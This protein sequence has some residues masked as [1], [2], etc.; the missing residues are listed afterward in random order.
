M[1]CLQMFDD[2]ESGE[3]DFQEFCR[4]LFPDLDSLPGAARMMNEDSEENGEEHGERPVVRDIPPPRKNP[5]IR[6]IPPPSKNN[7]KKMQN[8]AALQGGGA[9]AFAAASSLAMAAAA[10][11][12]EAAS[13]D[14]D[15]ATDAV[16]HITHNPEL[17]PVKS[18]TES[19][20]LPALKN[21]AF[22]RML[23][24]KDLS[25]AAQ[26]QTGAMTET[27]AAGDKVEPQPLAAPADEPRSRQ[28]VIITDS[29]IRSLPGR[30]APKAMDPYPNVD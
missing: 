16:E 5:T 18:R 4:L 6:D 28:S 25:Q 14:G 12:R 24:N 30:D 26:P 10:A 1:I 9:N 13:C 21:N 7:F 2:D 27:R 29:L 3:I 17:P 11:K 8:L 23:R 20:D 19:A 22:S 15:N